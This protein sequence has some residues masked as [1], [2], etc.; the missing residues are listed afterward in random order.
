MNCSSFSHLTDEI[1]YINNDIQWHPRADFKLQGFVPYVLI[2]CFTS[3]N[4]L[5]RLLLPLTLLLL[6]R[7][8]FGTSPGSIKSLLSIAGTLVFITDSRMRFEPVNIQTNK[9]IFFRVHNISCYIKAKYV[10]TYQ[11]NQLQHQSLGHG[12]YLRYHFELFPN[13][14][15]WGSP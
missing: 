15:F 1:T 3:S 12:R 7:C 13:S 9:I 10:L 6:P 2:I 5:I 4:N 8:F 14:D 11:V